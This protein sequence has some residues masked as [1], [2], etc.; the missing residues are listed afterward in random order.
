[1]EDLLTENLFIHSLGKPWLTPFTHKRALHTRK[2]NDLHFSQCCIV[3]K[4]LGTHP[5]HLLICSRFRV[6]RRGW[7][8]KRN[9]FPCVLTVGCTLGEQHA[10]M[11]NGSRIF[12]EQCRRIAFWRL[13]TSGVIL[14]NFWLMGSL[15][16]HNPYASPIEPVKEKSR[17][18]W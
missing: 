9:Q 8:E 7:G 12:L 14:K 1:M 17:K 15:L 5:A 11:F 16:N 18:R 13:M 10:I 6:G 3:L 4:I 2:Q